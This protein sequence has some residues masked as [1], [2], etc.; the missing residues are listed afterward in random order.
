MP[1]LRKYIIQALVPILS[2]TLLLSA[3]GTSEAS[4]PNLLD[5]PYDRG[6]FVM[7]TYVTMRVYDEGKEDTLELAF[8]RVRELDKMLSS[9]DT[10]SQIDTINQNAGKEPVITSDE[11]FTLI[12]AAAE[13]SDVL[14]GGFDYTIGP[15]T[16]LWRIGFDDA[17]VPEPEEIEAI[18]PLVSHELVELN[19]DVQTVF[20]TQEG[21]RLDLGA[22]AK[23]Y[24][25]DEVIK[26]LKDNGV[27]TSIIDLGGNIVVMGDS[28]TRE[29]G[30]F[31]V[32]IQ[33]PNS[34]RNAYI[35]TL[36]LRNKSIVTSGIYERFVEKDGVQYHHLL[37]PDT[38]YPFENE[39]ASVTII[40]DKS[41]DGDGLSTTV[42]AM[43]LEAGRAYVEGVDNTD[44]IFITK[45][46]DV[47]VTSGIEEDFVL[48]NEEYNWVK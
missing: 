2:L 20:L 39:L 40:S 26:V 21:M 8:D 22:I 23:G 1:K 45:D 6:E 37:H 13:Y 27:T 11:V 44:A 25:A 15:L 38:G 14:G 35:G 17:R 9:N 19:S 31:N 28:P 47:Y 4:E 43:G 41:I 7:G 36:L 32:G 46:N 42:F 29:T 30:G 34:V 24:I 18:L 33:D 16:N 5:T 12:V 48:T 10:G 3:C